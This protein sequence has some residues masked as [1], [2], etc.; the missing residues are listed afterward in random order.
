[1]AAWSC[2]GRVPRG[3]EHEAPRGP[4]LGGCGCAC[5]PHVLPFLCRQEPRFP[6]PAGSGWG[7]QGMADLRSVLASGHVSVKTQVSIRRPWAGPWV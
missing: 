2:E 7:V 1:M 6:A 4:F 5:S 3:R